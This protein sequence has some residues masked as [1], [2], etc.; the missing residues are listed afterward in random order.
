[1]MDTGADLQHLDLANE[2]WTNPGDGTSHGYDFIDNVGTVFYF[3]TDRNAPKKRIVA[4][5]TIFAVATYTAMVSLRASLVGRG[6]APAI[7]R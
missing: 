1:V 2:L 5:D 6:L 4:I 7:P 3:S